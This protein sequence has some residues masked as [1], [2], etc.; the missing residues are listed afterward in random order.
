MI[1]YYQAT[2][3]QSVICIISLT[4]LI[5]I[6]FHVGLFLKQEH[7]FLSFVTSP[8]KGFVEVSVFYAEKVY[9]VVNLLQ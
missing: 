7:C 3:V 9:P 1:G 8:I 4:A 6:I 5:Y 2:N